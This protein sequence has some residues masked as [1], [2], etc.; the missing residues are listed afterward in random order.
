LLGGLAGCFQSPSP[1]PVVGCEG[2]RGSTNLARGGGGSSS[3]AAT[4]SSSGGAGSSGG[5]SSTVSSSNSTTGSS[6]G[7]VTTSV[8]IADAGG[9]VAP[10]L[11]LDSRIY[12]LATNTPVAGATVGAIGLNGVP[13]SGA[14]AVSDANGRFAI[15]LPNGVEVAPL[16]QAQDYPTT[17]ASNFDLTRP[18]TSEGDRDGIPLASSQL[19]G[20]LSGLLPVNIAEAA[21]LVAVNSVSGTAPCANNAA[22]WTLS[23]G[24][25]DGG[26][27][28]DGGYAL[29]YS[30]TTGFPAA[31]LTETSANGGAMF[32]NV[33][34]S[35]SNLLSVEATNP[36]A[37]PCAIDL[38]S[39]MLTGRLYAAAGAVTI[40]ALPTP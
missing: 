10:L 32:F 30:G 31:G 3:R 35:L 19:L 16:V 28:P 8:G 29:Y 14:S 39:L 1:T 24:L 15:C 22:G 9:C 40:V 12:D 6:S 13:V 18:L 27:L 34:T 21:V 23:L 2:C 7:S 26:P 37:G 17:Y 11:E 33:D 38:S 4:G 25:G 20:S 36:D 5:S